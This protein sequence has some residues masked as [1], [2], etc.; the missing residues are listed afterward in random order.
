M[1]LHDRLSRQGE[2]GAVLSVVPNGQGLAA[3]TPT[4]DPYAE[5]K[6]KVHHA[7]IAK[8]GP[9][10]FKQDGTEELGDRVYRAV[11]EELAL[12][13]TTP[14]TPDTRHPLLRHL[15]HHILL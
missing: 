5:L 8:L 15:T 10:L 2:D 6:A 7:C 11:T 12:H 13:R 9:E 4:V 1:G 3:S 14:L